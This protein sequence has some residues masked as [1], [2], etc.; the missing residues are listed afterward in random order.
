MAYQ[1]VEKVSK[2]YLKLTRTHRRNVEGLEWL[3]LALMNG[4][5]A[6]DRVQVYSG[7]AYAQ[8]FCNP[9][10]DFSGSMRP[11][12]EGVYQIGVM[13]Y[14]PG[15]W[16]DGLG[17]RYAALDVLPQYRANNR[18]AIGLHLDANKAYSPGSAGCVVT[19]TE[20][21]LDRV[22]SWLDQKSQPDRLVV[23]Y[24]LGFLVSRGYAEPWSLVA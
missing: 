5:T 3:D 2:A 19:A 21:V 1:K 4:A 15:T 8:E 10:S 13:E 6:V 17:A 24:E 14:A 7:Q 11:I 12:P 20:K 22:V 16:G 9:G 23:D 18:A